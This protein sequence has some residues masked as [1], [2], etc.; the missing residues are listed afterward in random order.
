MVTPP[1][2]TLNDVVGCGSEPTSAKF[3]KYVPL[4]PAGFK[5]S[6]ENSVAMYSLLLSLLAGNVNWVRVS[7]KISPQLEQSFKVLD[8][9]PGATQ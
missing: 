6:S 5:P 8:S 1:T 4:S 9:S 2:V 3:W 7:Q